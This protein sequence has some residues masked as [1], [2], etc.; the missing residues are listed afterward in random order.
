MYEKALKCTKIAHKDKVQN[1]MMKGVFF[2]K[3]PP[4]PQWFQW[5]LSTAMTHLYSTL[6][7]PITVSHTFEGYMGG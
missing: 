7:F 3:F 2:P 5:V 6:T 1:L 4:P